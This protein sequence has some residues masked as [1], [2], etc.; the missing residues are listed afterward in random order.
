MKNW[1]GVLDR[2]RDEPTT[3]SD[4]PMTTDDRKNGEFESK[5]EGFSLSSQKRVYHD[6]N[7]KEDPPKPE[8]LL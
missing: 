2:T 5:I 6:R 1:Q 7:N 3:K 4:T 8:G